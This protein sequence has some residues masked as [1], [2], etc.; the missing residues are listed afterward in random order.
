MS[1]WK[2]NFFKKRNKW[3]KYENPYTKTHIYTH[4]IEINDDNNK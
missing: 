2:R 4:K 3:E 1:R